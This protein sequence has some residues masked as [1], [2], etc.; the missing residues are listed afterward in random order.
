MHSHTTAT[1]QDIAAAWHSGHIPDVVNVGVGAVVITIT[2]TTTV[3][4]AVVVIFAVPLRPLLCLWPL[5]CLWPLYL[6]STVL[7]TATCLHAM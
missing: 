4:V 3:K 7:F 5:I 6:P 2:G 1:E